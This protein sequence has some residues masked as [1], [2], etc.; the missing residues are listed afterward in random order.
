[1]IL[2]DVI[3]NILRNK[4][5]LTSAELF[6]KNN[7][8]GDDYGTIVEAVK[9]SLEETASQSKRMV[10]ELK[11]L[12]AGD[13][14]DAAHGLKQFLKVRE[15]WVP[16]QDARCLKFVEE[17]R[18]LTDCPHCAK[19]QA[20]VLKEMASEGNAHLLKTSEFTARLA[21]ALTKLQ[22]ARRTGNDKE[23]ET[24]LEDKVKQF[25]KEIEEIGGWYYGR[26][27]A[28]GV[29]EASLAPPMGPRLS[30]HLE[31]VLWIGVLKGGKD[32]LLP[33]LAID[34]SRTSRVLLKIVQLVV[35]WPESKVKHA[36]GAYGQPMCDGCKKYG[37]DHSTISADLNYCLHE[38][39]SEKVCFNGVRDKGR[40]G[41]TIDYFVGLPQATQTGMIKPEA[42]SLRF[43]SSHSFGAVTDPLRDPTRETEHPLATITYS[44]DQAIRKQLKWGAKDKDAASQ[45]V[46]W[47]GFSDLKISDEFKERGGTEFA[48][49]ST[50]TDVRVAVGYAIRKTTTGG[51]LLMRIVTK[52]NLERG[53]DL[54]WISMFP[55]EAERL[56]APLTFMN[57]P[58]KFQE[59]E[60]NGVN[61]QT[62]KL[63]VVEIEVTAPPMS[64]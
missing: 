5:G 2:L 54:Q 17:V 57:K 19:V 63:T 8:V 13:F 58:E 45:K 11:D 27:N 48:P 62:V 60:V 31:R 50:T 37:L 34:G 53:M 49:M 47:R 25:R 42:V 51:A 40:A 20:D 23:E 22:T 12:R 14:A 52:N 30:W 9:K 59:I 18:R 10:G 21:E 32:C 33:R 55:G 61:D 36:W 46:Y 35:A 39:S 6:E 24:R 64:E 7:I 28:P 3:Q 56:L 44:I 15:D 38:V 26:K 4:K 43:Y 1:M 16:E 41:K 29:V